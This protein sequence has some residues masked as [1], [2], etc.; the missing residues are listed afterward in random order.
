[1]K[2]YIAPALKTLCGICLLSL[3]AQQAT[4]SGFRVPEA[5]IAGLGTSSALVANPTELGAGPYNPAAMSFLGGSHLA[6][7]VTLV[8]PDLNVT[9]S[10]GPSIGQKISSQGG[11][12]HLAA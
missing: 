2:H 7:G 12:L 1:M 3:T 5:S 4:A 8:Q 11:V 9:P 6:V 10:E